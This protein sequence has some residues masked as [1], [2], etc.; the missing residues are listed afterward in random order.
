[1]CGVCH[2]RYAEGYLRLRWEATGDED[3]FICSDCVPLRMTQLSQ[4]RGVDAEVRTLEGE[5]LGGL[6]TAP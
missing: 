6:E 3:Q 5:V 4:M 1:M 2:V